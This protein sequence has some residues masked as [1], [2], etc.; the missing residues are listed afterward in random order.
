[1]NVRAGGILVIAGGVLVGLAAMLPIQTASIS[2][3]PVSMS[4]PYDGAFGAPAF[5]VAGAVLVLVGLLVALGAMPSGLDRWVPVVAGAAVVVMALIDLQ[6]VGQ[7]LGITS[8]GLGWF[9]AVG[10]GIV[11]AVGG[12]LVPADASEVSRRKVG[13]AWPHGERASGDA[14]AVTPSG[15]APTTQ[16]A[17]VD[18][19]HVP[20]LLRELAELREA[21]VITPA[22]F[23]AKKAA[24]L[25]RM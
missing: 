6:G 7:F 16:N 3:G 22:E 12:V 19:A 8:T 17:A 20:G 9:S 14:P 11:S 18:P 13:G 5:L 10:G 2:V 24:L 4:Q 23:E 21:G 25:E 15:P 1:M